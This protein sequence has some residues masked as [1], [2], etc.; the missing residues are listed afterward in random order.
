M[1]IWGFI[2]SLGSFALSIYA[3]IKSISAKK[4]VDKV[5]KDKDRQEDLQRLANVL[6]DLNK[7]S[8][9]LQKFK[10]SMQ[11][12]KLPD[13]LD[14]MD[15]LVHTLR[16]GLPICWNDEHVLAKQVRDQVKNIE[17]QIQ[18]F[19][20]EESQTVNW[21]YITGIIQNLI[22]Q[23]KIEERKMKNDQLH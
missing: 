20:D 1:E 8:E 16:T 4:A 22:W 14:S 11:G 2:V 3:I 18:L 21:V 13:I 19:R 15:D 5:I 7:T 17:D 10:S 23:L 9:K 6:S 12:M